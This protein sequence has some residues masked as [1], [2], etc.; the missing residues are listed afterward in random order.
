[1]A[2]GLGDVSPEALLAGERG[3]P[4]RYFVEAPR[5]VRFRSLPFVAVL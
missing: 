1:M 5:P 2:K 4:P 3:A